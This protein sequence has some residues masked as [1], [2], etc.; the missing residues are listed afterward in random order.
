MHTIVERDLIGGK[1]EIANHEV[2]FGES[3]IEIGFEPAI[4]LHSI[5]KSIADNADGRPIGFRV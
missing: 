5:C 1:A 3:V 4:V 2:V